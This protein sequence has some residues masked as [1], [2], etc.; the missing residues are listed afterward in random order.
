MI[1]KKLKQKRKECGCANIKS[2]GQM[3]KES[4]EKNGL[5]I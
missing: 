2:N 1:G 3:D 4:I 5:N